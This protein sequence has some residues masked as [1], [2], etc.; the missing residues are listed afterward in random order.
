M[1]RAMERHE[2]GDAL[3]IP[4]ILRSCLWTDTPFG[5]LNATP[6]DGKPITQWPDRDQAFTEIA[7]AIEKSDRAI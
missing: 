1:R 2:A 4:V 5:K 6:P 3:V 7:I